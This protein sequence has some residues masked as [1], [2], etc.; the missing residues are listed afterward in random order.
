LYFKCAEVYW[1]LKQPAAALTCYDHAIQID[2][3]DAAAHCNRGLAL[4]ELG[5]R[6][7]ALTAQDEAIKLNPE[8][9]GAHSKRGILLK[10]LGQYPAALSSLKKAAELS[11]EV[12]LHQ[13]NLA[14][15]QHTLLQVNDALC[16]YAR[17]LSIDPTLTDASWNQTLLLLSAGEWS[18][19]WPMFEQRWRL[20]SP[21][22]PKRDPLT[23]PWLGK[24]ALVGKTIL[25]HSEQGLGD[26]L[27]FC[28][29]APL[30]ARLGAR[31]ILEVPQQL[32]RLLTSLEGV[33]QLIIQGQTRPPFDA[34]C[35][36]MSLP[37]AFKTTPENIPGTNGYLHSN[38]QLVANWQQ[39]LGHHQ[40]PR[41]GLAW[42]GHSNNRYNHN[43]SLELAQLLPY[44]P[45]NCDYFV[46]QK[47]IPEC[48]QAS[49]RDA[50]HIQHYSDQFSDFADTAAFCQLMDVIVSVDTSLAHLAGALGKPTWILLPTPP[51]WRWLIERSDSVWYDSARLY[52]QQEIG[53]WQTPL[54]QLEADL[55]QLKRPA[56]NT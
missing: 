42:S 38:P 45:N 28:R 12:A 8:F 35:P 9:P 37:L 4:R 26:T 55:Q 3:N 34:H 10:E 29:Y 50:G 25:L 39:Q 7:A 27:Q 40:R 19:G 18:R 5:Q 41:V 36:L 30:V 21:G 52:R 31:V 46:L 14:H 13:Y 15:I 17:A 44:L 2:P 23:P 49:L 22:S 43:R 6:H 48:D 33:A 53:N 1:R 16:S 20:K 11:P 32:H 54:R 56:G 51:E 24:T 47:D